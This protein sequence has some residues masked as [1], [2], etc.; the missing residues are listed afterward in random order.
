MRKLKIYSLGLGLLVCAA[1]TGLPLNAQSKKNQ[2]QKLVEKTIR[3]HREVTGLELSAAPA[4]QK[5]CITIAATEAGDLGQAC[6]EDEHAA[7]KTLKPYVEHEADGYDVTAPLRDANGK[8]VGV[9]GIDF[10]PEAGQ[11]DTEILG[12]TA[13]LLQEMERQIPSKEFLFQAASTQ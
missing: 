8:L 11:T 5:N 3:I 2:A 1:L 9:M 12:L 10:K 4:G 7:L 6:D 13:T